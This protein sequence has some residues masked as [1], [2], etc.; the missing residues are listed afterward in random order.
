MKRLFTER[1][2]A[3]RPRTEEVL[4][5][6]CLTG[7]LSLVASRIDEHWFGESFPHG[8]RQ[9]LSVNSQP[10]PVDGFKIAVT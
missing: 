6:D 4:S 9:L 5:D 8:P 7:L 10:T 1:Y 2:G 3:S